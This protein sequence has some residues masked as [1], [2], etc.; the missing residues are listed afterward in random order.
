MREGMT[1]AGASITITS[2]TNA[3]AFWLGY[4]GSLDALSSF[5][6]FAGFGVVFLYLTSITMFAAFMVW[7]IDR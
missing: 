3:V 4:F 7:D 1:H 5:C 6:L 2:F